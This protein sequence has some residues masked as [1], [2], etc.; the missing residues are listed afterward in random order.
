MYRWLLIAFRNQLGCDRIIIHGC[1]YFEL[2]GLAFFDLVDRLALGNAL[3]ITGTL[4][5]SSCGPKLGR[6]TLLCAPAAPGHIF[7]LN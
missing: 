1:I 7:N 4:A 2:T 6:E 3:M 5:D